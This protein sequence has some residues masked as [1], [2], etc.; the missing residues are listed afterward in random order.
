MKNVKRAQRIA[1]PGPFT[2]KPAYWAAAGA[3]GAAGGA[4][5]AP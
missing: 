2:I 3:A 5:G 4:G 1:A